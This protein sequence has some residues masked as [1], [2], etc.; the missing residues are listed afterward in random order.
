MRN[1]VIA[2]LCFALL[3]AACTDEQNPFLDPD[4]IDVTVSTDDSLVAVGDT[5][6]LVL[7]VYLPGLVDSIVLD[8]DRIP[9][10]TLPLSYHKD[11]TEV[12]ISLSRTFTDTADTGL[13]ECTILAYAPGRP[14]PILNMIAFSVGTAPIVLSGPSLQG[15]PLLGDSCTLEI[16]AVGAAPLE[17][18]W[19]RNSIRL[20]SAD[21]PTLVFN[22][23]TADDSGTYVCSLTNALGTTAS[24]PYTLVPAGANSGPTPVPSVSP[25][26]GDTAPY[27]AFAFSWQAAYDADGN[28]ISY[29]LALGTSPD[30]LSFLAET[31]DTSYRPPA[32]LDPG[33]TYYWT[34]TVTAGSDSVRCPAQD[35]YTFVV[36]RTRPTAVGA[37]FPADSS[38]ASAD[39]F[40]FSWQPATDE[41]G[42]SITYA[43][44]YGTAPDSLTIT[45]T[46]A[47]TS[48]QPATPL[49]SGVTY[50]WTITVMSGDDS[51][52][53]PTEGTFSFTTSTSQPTS[54]SAVS[55]A[56]GSAVPTDGFA[57]SWA[58]A[59]DADGDQI[60]YVVRYGTAPSSLDLGSAVTDTFYQPALTLDGN[61]DYYWTI[62]VVAGNDSVRCPAVGTYA[63]ST[64]DGKAEFT[65]SLNDTAASINDSLTFVIQA[66]DPEGISHYAWDFNGDGTADKIT[67]TPTA[68]DRFNGL[69]N[70]QVIVSVVDR[71][72]STTADTATVTI[73]NLAP[74]IQAIGPDTLVGL[75]DTVALSV[76]IQD[77][78]TGTDIS[79]NVSRYGEFTP[80]TW[81]P[82]S[83]PDTIF[84]GLDRELPDS[85]LCVVRVVDE[86]GNVSV[87]SVVVRQNM[88]WVC[89]TENAPWSARY[90][91]QVV[92]LGDSLW[93]IG[94]D[95][96]STSDGIEWEQ[97]CSSIQPGGRVNFGAAYYNQQLYIAGGYGA[98]KPYMCSD[99]WRTSTGCSWTEVDA[100][101]EFNDVASL[102]LSSFKGALFAIGGGMAGTCPSGDCYF[103]YN[104]GVW[105]S[106][107]GSDWSKSGS[108][109]WR[110][111]H[112]T[113]VFRDS[114]WVLAGYGG[115]DGMRADIRKSADGYV[116]EEA[117]DSA[118]FG[119]RGRF[120]ATSTGHA[121]VVIGG[122]ADNAGGPDPLQ[123]SSLH[124]AWFSLDGS[125][126]LCATRSVPCLPRQDHAAVYWRD[127]LYV[128]GGW[129]AS[130]TLSDVWY[131]TDLPR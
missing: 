11:S 21:S 22:P 19:S 49:V 79:W 56:D 107:T 70:I 87:D 74:T 37:V 47:D 31:T 73:T 71:T 32:P 77:D 80:G 50:Y 68:G 119:N 16:T 55:P 83:S 6:S 57:F 46:T 44:A 41:D 98:C 43:L 118:A 2:A 97:R 121:L 15:N 66:T 35:A 115:Y 9:D 5:L 82:V 113:V 25:V 85:L 120:T 72:D 52:R 51:V 125:S 60:T 110:S 12:F 123:P 63:F 89:V 3:H 61:T 30:A 76:S 65:R 105:T 13:H 67:P 126:W 108:V 78:G 28:T 93:L 90:G 130:E 10:T 69:G 39:D 64:A 116:W 8:F 27:E 24:G 53:C 128:F 29:S 94:D 59:T 54:V 101:P 48:Y 4:N 34:I 75:A 33:R 45:D 131:T 58:P 18:T 88:I 99:V 62:T 81:N 95:L 84:T 104:N 109:D 111:E 91:H 38:I 42:D 86:D 96:W 100:D 40:R 92:V 112:C 20:D 127:R 14:D 106:T 1:A 26:D 36:G 122:I 124:D 17:Y 129:S 102:T 23:L 7:D 117:I 103:T 114:L